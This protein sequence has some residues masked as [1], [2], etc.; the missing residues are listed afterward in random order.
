MTLVKHPNRMERSLSLD[1]G[2]KGLEMIP[3]LSPTRDP[4]KSLASSVFPYIKRGSRISD[5]WL[6]CLTSTIILNPLS[7]PMREVL[8]SS[9]STDPEMEARGGEVICPKSGARKWQG[10]DSNPGRCKPT[11]RI[12]DLCDIVSEE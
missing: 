2:Q 8:M 3:D 9:S 4:A 12:P 11:A 10:W 7:S 6:Q 5:A 1:E